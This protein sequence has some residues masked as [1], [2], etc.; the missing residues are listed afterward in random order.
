MSAHPINLGL[1][2]LLE[3]ANW[4]AMGYW[5]WSQHQG[6]GRFV[7]GVGL[8]V[9]AMAVWGVFRVPNDPGNAPVAVPGAIRLA[10][11]LVEFG[12][13]AALLVA[14]GRP[15]LGIA[16]AAIVVAHYGISYDRIARLL[17][18]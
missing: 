6:L 9:L 14:A 5:G 11:E 3:L 13:G 10:I 2:F 16:F 18:Q 12:L 7:W 1:R 8:P 4:A 15:T 17:R